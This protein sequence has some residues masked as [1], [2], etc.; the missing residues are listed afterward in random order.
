MKNNEEIEKPKH[1]DKLEALDN[2]SLG[3]SIVVAIAIGFGIGYGL[4]YLTGYTWTLWLGIFWGIAAAA[5][6][7]YKAYKRAQ[8][9]YEGME[10]DPRYSYRAKHGDKSF[11]D[12]D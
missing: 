10:N 6:N 9:S 1:R 2:M 8:K 5:L 4:K 12:E 7:I 11:D 3:I